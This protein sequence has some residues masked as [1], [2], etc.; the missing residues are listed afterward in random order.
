MSLL[1]L[2]EANQYTELIDCLKF[3]GGRKRLKD[4]LFRIFLVFRD[5]VKS[6]D[7][8]QILNRRPKLSADSEDSEQHGSTQSA[9]ILP[10]HWFSMRVAI[11]R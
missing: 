2:M 9:N 4:F 1:K 8:N 10:D 11:N 7:S 5:T 3:V 6:N